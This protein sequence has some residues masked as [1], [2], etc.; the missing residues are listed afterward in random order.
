MQE[1]AGEL[2]QDHG[3]DPAKQPHRRAGF[4]PED[5]DEETGDDDAGGER[6]AELPVEEIDPLGKDPASYL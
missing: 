2:D 3:G 4:R 1:K 5:E 6:D